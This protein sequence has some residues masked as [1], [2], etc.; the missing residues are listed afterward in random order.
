MKLFILLP[1]YGILGTIGWITQLVVSKTMRRRY[2]ATQLLQTLKTHKIFKNVS[3]VGLASSHPATCN[4]LAKYAGV[5]VDEI[6]LEFIKKN[7]SKILGATSVPY[8]KDAALRG[9]LFQE[10]DSHDPGVVSSVD[11][12]F[13]VDHIE[14]LRALETFQKRKEWCLGELLDGHE[15]LVLLPVPPIEVPAGDGLSPIESLTAT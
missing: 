15:F 3:V 5:K 12:E 1:I 7:A 4:A 2:I 14:P 9:S 11:T 10:N 6:D 8:V 13:F